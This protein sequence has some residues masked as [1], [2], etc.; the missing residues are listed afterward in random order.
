MLPV[1]WTSF[2]YWNKTVVKDALERIY[3]LH[4]LSRLSI[5]IFLWCEVFLVVQRHLLSLTQTHQYVCWFGSTVCCVI[6]SIHYGGGG[7]IGNFLI[8]EWYLNDLYK[9]WSTPGFEPG[10]SCTF[11][12]FISIPKQESYP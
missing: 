5:V 2:C 12:L 7:M 6:S 9:S 11:D 8:V 3:P 1:V 10:T 4:I